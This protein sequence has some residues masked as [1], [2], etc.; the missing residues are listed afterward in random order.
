MGN[1]SFWNGFYNLP[2]KSFTSGVLFVGRFSITVLIFLL[3]N[4]CSHFLFHHVSVLKCMFL[5]FY[6]FIL[7]YLIF[8]II[9]H[10][11]LLWSFVFL[12][13]VISVLILFMIL[14]ILDFFLS[15]FFFF[16][17]SLA[18]RLLNFVYLFRKPTQFHWTSVLLFSLFYSL[19]FYSLLFPS[20]Y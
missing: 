11:S 9:L 13:L 14:F 1:Y 20:F 6:P 4:S 3:V 2:V 19:L 15:F 17:V 18:K 8:C 5:R 16:L 7:G 12:L 10:V